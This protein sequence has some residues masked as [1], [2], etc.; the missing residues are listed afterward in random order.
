MILEFYLKNCIESRNFGP[1]PPMAVLPLPAPELMWPNVRTSVCSMEIHNI[2]EMAD[3][4]GLH[5][6]D[7]SD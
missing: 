5:N 3:L 7:V 6:S 4:E 1:D 2:K